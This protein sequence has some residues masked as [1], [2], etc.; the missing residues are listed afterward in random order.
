MHSQVQGICRGFGLTLTNYLYYRS[1]HQEV[2]SLAL[3][4][5]YLPVKCGLVRTLATHHTQNGRLTISESQLDNFVYLGQ[6]WEFYQEARSQRYQ[7][8]WTAR[9]RPD[10]PGNCDVAE[11]GLQIVNICAPDAL[12]DYLDRFTQAKATTHTLAQNLCLV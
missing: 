1:L 4:S 9:E 5:T 8:V 3:F 10:L 2:A 12:R 11:Y 7:L 6:N